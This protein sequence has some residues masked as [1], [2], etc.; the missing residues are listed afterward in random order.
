[1]REQIYT[2]DINLKKYQVANYKQYDN[3]INYNI[4]LVDNDVDIDL[5]GYTAI[6][7]FK[8]IKGVVFQKDCIINNSIVTTV[9][10]NNI[11]A[12]SGIVNAE[13]RFSLNDKQ[14]R[15]FT[16]KL[17][18]QESIDL[19]DAVQSVPK[20]D[21]ID[22][23]LNFDTNVVAPK[24]ESMQNQ[25]DI[26]I[27]AMESTFNNLAP[28]QS[29]NVEVQLAR[30]D[31]T[32]FEHPSLKVRLLDID[33]QLA[34]KAT[35]GLISVNDIN[36]NLGKFDQ[37]YM[38]DQLL[39]Q[40]AG[41]TPINAVPADESLPLKKTTFYARGTNLFNKN[42]IEVDKYILNTTG[43]ATISTGF[44]ASGFIK[45]DSLS[46]Y[47]IKNARH[48]AFYDSSKI[49]I[50]G[51]NASSPYQN[52]LISSPANTRYIRFSWALSGESLE[53]QRLNIGNTLLSYE[54]YKEFISRNY[55]EN[56]VKIEDIPN[57]LITLDKVNFKR[58][59]YNL[60]NNET[61]T[62]DSF[63]SNTTGN[64]GYASGFVASDYCSIL[65]D[66]KYVI[67][68]AR[69]YAFYDIDKVFISGANTVNPYLNIKLTSP[70]NAKYIRFS[71]HPVNDSIAK[72]KQQLNQGEEIQT[73]ESFGLNFIIKNLIEVD[74]SI[75]LLPPT[76][77]VVVG[78][79][80][81]IYF[82]NIINKDLKNVRINVICSVGK[83]LKDRF[84]FN[85][86][87][88]GTYKITIEVYENNNLVGEISSNIIV[89]NSTVGSGINKKVLV[90]GDSTINAGYS[91]QRVLD[92]FNS[93]VMDVTLLGSRGNAP[94]LYEGRGGWTAG[95]YRTNAIY[96]SVI[97]PFYNGDFDFNYYMVQKGYTS[98]DYVVINLG[99]NDTFSFENDAIL[100]TN[101]NT[102][103]SNYD[104]IINNIKNYNSTIKIALNITIPPNEN[105]D[106]FG[107]AYGCG[108]TQWRYKKNNEIWVKKLID[109]YKG[110]EFQNIYLMPIN[111]NIDC[112]NNI[113]D[114]VHP[115]PTG[116]NQIGDIMYY[117]LKSFES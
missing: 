105:Q 39:Q 82:Q 21:I 75:V 103:I 52:I 7:I 72:E 70:A 42:D 69:H 24:L 49:F 46:T 91:T 84:N 61:V 36:K 62:N 14:I 71:W 85:P 114:A 51:T 74:K 111:L 35:K 92:N 90:I 31:A 38:S 78:K 101:I 6:S 3:E 32:G 45:I 68:A 108:Q 18:I 27:G 11:L 86:T 23:L 30:K 8:N 53:I 13:F 98:V 77:P 28:D 63:V 22:N 99:I 44:I 115:T 64:L 83:Q 59:S 102:I 112:A 96:E 117:W 10:D 106:A 25:V 104:F 109:Y 94:N 50:S 67:A 88:A 40:I 9:L 41:N 55:L 54:P 60:F 1:M 56:E 43:V 5:E 58:P 66:T 79:E 15:T 37:T 113:S 57:D 12:E 110:K 29:A 93:D 97:N 89:K 47:I 65:N 80:L 95:M 100:T 16:L 73:Y 26:S 2:V 107:N 116:Y 33:T 81:N 76:I 48:Y 34:E 17:D 87:S 19:G 20:W 4:R